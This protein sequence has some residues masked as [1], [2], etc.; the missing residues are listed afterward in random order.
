MSIHSN[1][2]ELPSDQ[3]AVHDLSSLSADDLEAHI[4]YC[5]SLM[6]AAMR[7]WEQFGLVTYMAHACALRT[8][9]ERAIKSRGPDQVK[10]MEI[11][12]GLG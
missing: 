11:A 9:M 1:V 10:R 4:K 6:E 2:V 5:G 3:A 12:L 7:G 8:S